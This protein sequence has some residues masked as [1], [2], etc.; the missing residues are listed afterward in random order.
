MK[1]IL[2]SLPFIA[3]TALSWGVYGP[4]LH[5]GQSVMGG[6]RLRPLLC[7]GMAYFVI[8]VVVPIVVLQGYGE[9]GNW[10]TSGIFWSS[11]AGAAG[12]I[13]A[14]GII[15][16]FAVG[17]R[18]IYVMPLV[19]GCAPVINVFYSATRHGLWKDLNP[20]FVAGLILVA[21]GAST[22]LAFAPKPHS[23]AKAGGASSSHASA[24]QVVE[25]KL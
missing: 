8:A 14:L 24:P 10:T 1:E 18:P 13:G 23:A 17:G 12:A 15:L 16:A 6:S 4:V 5:E 11:A 21:V 2:Y 9:K 3:L 20:F 25:G 22:V 7:V 19:F